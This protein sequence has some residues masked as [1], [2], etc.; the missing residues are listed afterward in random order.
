MGPSKLP[1]LREVSSNWISGC[2]IK[3]YLEPLT[4]E[5]LQ[6]IHNAKKLEHE[7]QRVIKEARDEA[8]VRILQRRQQQ[9][10]RLNRIPLRQITCS[11][12][13]APTE[14][15]GVIKHATTELSSDI[16][17]ITET[18]QARELV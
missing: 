13:I 15:T 14:I 11:P 17:M 16:N 6:Q 4:Q 7:K 9:E 1:H 5:M 18:P 8:Q 12:I 10:G 2:R 3:K